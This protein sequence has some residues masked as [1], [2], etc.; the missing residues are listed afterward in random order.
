MR[1]PLTPDQ[2]K[3]IQNIAELVW[4]DNGLPDGKCGFDEQNVWDIGIRRGKRTREL[5]PTGWCHNADEQHLVILMACSH[6]E[7]ICPAS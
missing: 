2:T 6:Q 3:E 1:Y 7:A 5:Q 4:K